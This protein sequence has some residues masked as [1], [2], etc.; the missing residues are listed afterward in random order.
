[1][2]TQTDH[3]E[4]KE[5]KGRIPFSTWLILGFF[6]LVYQIFTFAK[7][8]IT[9]QI[10]ASLVTPA[11][12]ATVV[13]SLCAAVLAFLAFRSLRQGTKRKNRIELEENNNENSESN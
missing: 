2:S 11:I 7:G 9:H 5:T 4:R 10:E 6:Y 13:L 12:I 1:M 8:L 3:R